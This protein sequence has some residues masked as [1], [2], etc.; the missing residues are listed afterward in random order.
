MSSRKEQPSVECNGGT[1]DKST[2][3]EQGDPFEDGPERFDERTR[4]SFRN[5]YNARHVKRILP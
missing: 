2:L 1:E 5:G 3:Q 4:W